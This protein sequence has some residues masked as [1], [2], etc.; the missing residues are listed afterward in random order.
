MDP[1][2]ACDRA[3]ARAEAKWR[4]PAGLL[5]AIGAVESGRRD[6]GVA[7]RVAWPWTM[8]IAGAGVRQINKE[9]AVATVRSFQIGGFQVID[10]GCFQVDL[11]YH[12]EAFGTLEQAFDP[13]AN[14]DAAA[15]ILTGLHDRTGSWDRA[16]AAYHSASPA[17][18]ARYLAA[19]RFVWPGALVR[20]AAGSDSLYVQFLSPESGQDGPPLPRVVGPADPSV[21]VQWQA[22]A[23]EALPVVVDSSGG[24]ATRVVQSRLS[25]N[26]R[27]ARL[28][29]TPCLE[30]GSC[31]RRAGL[32]PRFR[33]GDH[34]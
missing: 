31:S 21:V 17:E 1:R 12:P 19:V 34:E 9:S 5:S 13:E 2:E 23:Q 20:G 3:A 10:V 11:F 27:R 28:I 25:T 7:G 8:N 6:L 29:R 18:G 30:R 24:A 14:A 32:S 22:P 33:E 26:R 15:R 4:I 16:T